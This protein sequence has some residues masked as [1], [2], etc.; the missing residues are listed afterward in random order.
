MRSSPSIPLRESLTG[1]LMVALYRSGRQTESLEVYRKTR[2]ALVEHFGIEPTA[3]LRGLEHAILTQDRSLDSVNNAEPP[4]S[5][6]SGAPV[7]CG[8]S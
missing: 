2:Q 6:D 5:R 8:T 7:G 1:R 3:E 4:S